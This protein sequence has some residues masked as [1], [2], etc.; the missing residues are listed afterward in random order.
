MGGSSSSAHGESLLPA[1][2]TQY[3]RIAPPEPS[4][5]WIVHCL[6]G[7][8]VGVLCGSSG[9][10]FA[11]CGRDSA[12]TAET[13]AAHQ[14]IALPLLNTLPDP[15]DGWE[16]RCRKGSEVAAAQGYTKYWPADLCLAGAKL[17]CDFRA[18]AWA[19]PSLAEPPASAPKHADNSDPVTDKLTSEA[20]YLFLPGTGTSTDKILSLTSAAADMGYHVIGLSYASLPTAVS[21]M[22]LWC[23]RQGANASLCNIELHESVLFGKPTTANGAAGLW[24]VSVAQSVTGLLTAALQQL[25]WSQYLT[26][27]GSTVRWDRVVVSGHS[28]GASHAAYLSVAKRVKAAVLFSGPQET[29]ECASWLGQG[30]PTLRRAV[31]ALKEECGDEPEDTAS[32]CARYPK[33]LRKNL[34]A[35][36]LTPGYV[37]N[38]SGYVVVDYPPLLNEGRSHHDSVALQNKASAPVEALWKAMLG[39]L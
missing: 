1:T 4:S 36:G 32:F 35:M 39:K 37:G 34:D 30:A 27:D 17:S 26:A 31:Y 9:A 33:R 14:K 6:M 8:A 19:S 18:A 20:L 24:D 2:E 38:H 22:G 5:R 7:L 23:T 10:Y 15:C 13:A 16:K 12:P 21:Q 25:E 3:H 29:P 11:F 28:Q